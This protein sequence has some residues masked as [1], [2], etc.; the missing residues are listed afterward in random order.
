MNDSISTNAQVI[1]LLTAPL[2][3]GRNDRTVKFLTPNEYNLVA[4][5]LHNNQKEPA[6]LLGP[7]AGIIVRAMPENM[8]PGRLEKL[9]ERGF[10][11]GQALERW[12]ARSIWLISR[13]DPSYPSRLKERLKDSAPVL[14]YGC[15][16]ETI[17]ESG[18]LAVVGSRE[19]SADLLKYAGNQAR[20]A[21]QAGQTVISGGARGIDRAAM[22]GALEG[23]GRVVGVLPDNLEQTI[24]ARENRDYLI[25]QQLV[26]ISACDPLA[27]FEAGQAMQR[28]K[29]I[30]ALAEAGLVIEAE[31]GQG[32]TWSGAVEQL[33]KLHLVPVY[34]R[35]EGTLGKGLAALLEKGALSWSNPATPADFQKI[36][37]TPAVRANARPLTLF[38]L[39][40]VDSPPIDQ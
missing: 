34:I 14:L 13:A 9:L 37:A 38:D 32:G 21:A 24:L 40:K 23:G 36:Y 10:Q 27:G 31:Y 11:L 29:L 22:S 15:G 1:L 7:D 2:S 12:Q 20:R 28:N 17:L 16:D 39:D 3:L 35:S 19:A 6:D 25:D 5:W 4:H 8:D 26:L 18:G 30:Y 33:E